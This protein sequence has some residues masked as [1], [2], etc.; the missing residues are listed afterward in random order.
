[1]TDSTPMTLEQAR[2]KV[3]FLKNE[4]ER[5]GNHHLKS[6]LWSIRDAIDD[7]LAPREVVSDEDVER[8]CAAYY[9]RSI[10]TALPSQADRQAVAGSRPGWVWV[11]VEPTNEMI[12]VARCVNYDLS[13]AMAERIYKAMLA[14]VKDEGKGNG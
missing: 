14:A 1:M 12:H 9:G 10:I 6:E 5:N 3:D 8:A 11:P 4:A 7:H 2:R 13:E